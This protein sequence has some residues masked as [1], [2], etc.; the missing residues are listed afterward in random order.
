LYYFYQYNMSSKQGSTVN[1]D[2]LRKVAGVTIDSVSN[3]LTTYQGEIAKVLTAGT[4]E[5]YRINAAASRALL[6]SARAFT[7]S[8][9][10][11]RT[12]EAHTSSVCFTRELA[13]VLNN[14]CK[15]LLEYLSDF[16]KVVGD[17]SSQFSPAT[18]ERIRIVN[19]V[20]KRLSRYQTLFAGSTPPQDCVPS[21]VLAPLSARKMSVLSNG[22]AALPASGALRQITASPV[23]D[24]KKGVSMAHAINSRLAQESI[25]SF[26]KAF[27]PYEEDAIVVY[28]ER[29]PTSSHG[30]VLVGGFTVEIGSESIVTPPR[31]I[32]ISDPSHFD[33]V[34]SRSF[35]GYDHWNFVGK[36]AKIGPVVLSMIV[37]KRIVGKSGESVTLLAFLRTKAGESEFKFTAETKKK[38]EFGAELALRAF[39]KQFTEY[40]AVPLQLVERGDLELS[41]CDYEEKFHTSKFKFGI[42]FATGSQGGVEDDMYC[43]EKGDV[44]FED[45]LNLLGTHISLRGWEKYRGGLDT[46]G[47]A[48]GSHGLY[49]DWRGFEIM[50]HV[51][52][53]LPYSQTNPQQV[54]RKRHLGNDIV[55]LIFH[56]GKGELNPSCFRSHFNHVFIVVRPVLISGSDEV[57]YSVSVILR[58]GVQLFPP[59]FPRGFLFAPDEFFREF[60]LT[61]LMNAELASLK[62]VEFA[63]RL[64]GVR[65]NML[66][67]IV[68]M[69]KSTELTAPSHP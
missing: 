57:R 17:L 38:D 18:L 69:T 3:L 44:L 41:L 28:S 55:V 51:S 40:S 37:H 8:N 47:D 10:E 59:H 33:Q 11:F 48:T 4:G 46:S 20:N 21:P 5:S 45:F 15:T 6:D 1:L 56:T 66:T 68:E 23:R 34:Y 31:P 60:I 25:I 7:E 65:R 64:A 24:K 26:Q 53:L 49:T 43:N 42:L 63:Q 14:V 62:S 29:G 12:T 19:F 2:V 27:K 67:D 22:P 50:F 35:F 36:E 13:E 52:T 9:G 30:V 39:K 16:G 32:M 61:K 54:E 58:A